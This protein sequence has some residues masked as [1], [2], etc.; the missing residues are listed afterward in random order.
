MQGNE[1]G[2]VLLIRGEKTRL[3]VFQKEKKIENKYLGKEVINNKETYKFELKYVTEY[4]E[5]NTIIWYNKETGL[6]EKEE[7]K[8]TF[9]GNVEGTAIKE[10][11]EILNYTYEFDVVKDEDI[12]KP[13]LEQYPDYT[14]FK[15]DYLVTTY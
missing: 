7:R 10:M 4:R 6:K 13:N 1:A 14:V 2:K 9:V 8:V 12:K 11:Y 3:H 5:E 15:Q